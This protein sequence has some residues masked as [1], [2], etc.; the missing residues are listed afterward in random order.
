MMTFFWVYLTDKYIMWPP[1]GF[2]RFWI[3]WFWM[4]TFRS[5]MRVSRWSW[6]QPH[7]GMGFLEQR[8]QVERA[9]T[10]KRLSL[11][12]KSSPMIIPMVRTFCFS[13]VDSNDKYNKMLILT[14][15]FLSSMLLSTNIKA[16]IYNLSF[17]IAIYIWFV[18]NYLF[19][20]L[21]SQGWCSS[22]QPHCQLEWSCLPIRMLRS[23]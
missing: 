13:I 23:R 8:P 21:H 12:W 15:D 18:F 10:L 9:S 1:F 11:W 14:W 17:L 19:V 2:S 20:C 6:C 5:S 4:M 22:R 7:Q 16:C 3:C